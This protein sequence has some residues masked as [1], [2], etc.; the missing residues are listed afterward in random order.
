MNGNKNTYNAFNQPVL[1]WATNIAIE[2]TPEL[3]GSDICLLTPDENLVFLSDRTEDGIVLD[4]DYSKRDRSIAIV[5]DMKFAPNYHRSDLIAVNDL[6]ARPAG[7][8]L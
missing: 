3:A 7:Q 8:G 4:T 6:R 2:P 1:Y 5:G